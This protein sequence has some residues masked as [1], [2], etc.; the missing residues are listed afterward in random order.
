[1]RHENRFNSVD[2]IEVVDWAKL[3]RFSSDIR[4]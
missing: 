2:G 4:R 1:M 3:K